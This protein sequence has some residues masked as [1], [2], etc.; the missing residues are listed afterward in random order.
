MGEVRIDPIYPKF[1][2]LR[3]IFSDSEGYVIMNEGGDMSA[4]E[5]QELVT[6]DSLVKELIHERVVFFSSKG[7]RL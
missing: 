5:I 2:I 1:P 4:K 6:E 3:I 7:V